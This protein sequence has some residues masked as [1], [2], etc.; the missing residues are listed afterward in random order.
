MK[1]S[2]ALS[3]RP[4]TTITALSIS[5]LLSACSIAITAPAHDSSNSAGRMQLSSPGKA[6]FECVTSPTGECNYALYTSRC[7]TA[8]G[9]GGKP[10]TTCTHQVFDE[11]TLAQGESREVRDLPSNYKQCMRVKGKPNVPN[12]D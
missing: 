10:A 6:R 4:F 7:Q 5:A 8:S 12:C 9:E 3:P 1:K 2:T 11:F